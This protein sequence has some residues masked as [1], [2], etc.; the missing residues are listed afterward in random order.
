VYGWSRPMA[1]RGEQRRGRHSREGQ[2]V[3]C[4]MILRGWPPTVPPRLER[5]DPIPAR[6]RAV[7]R[8]GC[9]PNARTWSRISTVFQPASARCPYRPAVLAAGP[10]CGQSPQQPLTL[11]AVPVWTARATAPRLVHGADR[12]RSLVTLHTAQ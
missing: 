12:R 3:Q 1:F 8:R 4:R 7:V 2:V 5:P 11:G 6:T 10:R 9:P